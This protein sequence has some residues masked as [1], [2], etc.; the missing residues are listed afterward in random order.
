MNKLL[1]K[2]IRKAGKPIFTGLPNDWSFL[3][4][5]DSYR[6]ECDDWQIR[7][8]YSANKKFVHFP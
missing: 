7:M 8:S 4:D 3:S 2:E 5:P 1:P 6:E